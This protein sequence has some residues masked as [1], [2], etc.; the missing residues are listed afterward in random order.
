MENNGSQAKTEKKKID[1]RKLVTKVV[2]AAALA[3]IAIFLWTS[4][5]AVDPFDYVTIAFDGARPF[6][7]P[8]VEVSKKAPKSIKASDFTFSSE[9][10]RKNKKNM[11]ILADEGQVFTVKYKGRSNPFKNRFFNRRKK[12]YKVG[13][14]PRYIHD[15]DDLDDP[16]DGQISAREDLQQLGQK[17]LDDSDDARKYK[18]YKYRGLFTQLNNTYDCDS[19]IQQTTYL[20]YTKDADVMNADHVVAVVLMNVAV[21]GRYNLSHLKG[22]GNILE[23]ESLSQ[24]SE[25][26]FFNFDKYDIGEDDS[27]NYSKMLGDYNRNMREYEEQQEEKKKRRH[28]W[29]YN[30]GGSS[31]SGSDDYDASDH[32]DEGYYDDYSSDFSSQDDADDGMEDDYDD[33]DIDYDDY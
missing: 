22:W 28:G 15:S 3:F 11:T 24:F 30:S 27:I 10:S 29:Y 21:D 8:R 16:N 20:I 1:K 14:T 2:T 33:G 7:I 19:R 25:F 26:G 9:Y 17:V 32:D 4:A 6:L 13:N 23:L 31:G 12:L 5:V 18:N